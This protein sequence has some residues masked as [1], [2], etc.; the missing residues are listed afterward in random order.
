MIAIS[1]P[2]VPG[3]RVCTLL[4]WIEGRRARKHHTP[5]QLVRIGREIA[6]LHQHSTNFSAPRGFTRPRWDPDSL[7]GDARLHAGWR[8]LTPTQHHLFHQVADRFETA[9]AHLEGAT[10]VFGLI[11]GD[12]DFENILF[13]RG[14][15][16]IIDFDDCGRGYYLYDIATL[17]DRIEW[18][19]DYPALREALIR[20]YR[21]ERTL[22]PDHERLLDLFLLIRWTFLGLA[23]L[24]APEHSPGRNYSARF[25]K[26]VMPKMTKYLRSLT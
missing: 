25:L 22:Q 17:L 26:I 23:F 16:H 3:E 9:A 7:L 20:G 18:R 5:D 21:Q 8:R 24:S 13:H 6:R 14:A 15:V 12:F 2:Q 4:T 19:E 1:A 11:H 10:E